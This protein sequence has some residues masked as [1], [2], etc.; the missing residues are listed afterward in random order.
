MVSNGTTSARFTASS[1]IPFWLHGEEVSGESSFEVTSP[2][3]GLALY[4]TSSA[5][6]DDVQRAVKS[7]QEALPKWSSTKPSL[8]R[9]IFLRVAEELKR[10]R[11]ELRQYSYRATGQSPAFFEIE[12]SAAINICISI[13]GLIQ[14]ATE[15]ASPVINDG[16]ALVLKEPWG[17]VLAISPWNAP[18]VLG[19]RAVLTPLAM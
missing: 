14:I 19:V 13:A 16:S 11:D 5:S 10:R 3:D 4:Q 2:I 8:R 6:E 15:S 7:A 9:D 1:T 18:Y 17:V 12:Y